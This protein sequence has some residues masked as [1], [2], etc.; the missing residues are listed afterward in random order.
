MTLAITMVI[1]IFKCRSARQ[2]RMWVSSMQSIPLSSYSILLCIKIWSITV[3][4][5]YA[6]L[7]NS[8]YT[9]HFY[10][11][12][13]CS[14]RDC[15][16]VKQTTASSALK[17]V[18]II[19]ASKLHAIMMI[20]IY[21][22]LPVGNFWNATGNKSQNQIYICMECVV[23]MKSFHMRDVFFQLY[24][25]DSYGFIVSLMSILCVCVEVND[26]AQ[27]S[28][29]L[30]INKEKL[31][32]FASWNA[33]EWDEWWLGYCLFAINI[34]Q[35][36]HTVV[37]FVYPERHTRKIRLLISF[38][39]FDILSLVNYSQLCYNYYY[40][41]LN[42]NKLKIVSV[43]FELIRIELNKWIFNKTKSKLWLTFFRNQW[44]Q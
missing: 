35:S 2:Y 1:I 7:L 9:I 32:K 23:C 31:I 28:W 29:Q 33:L 17:I 30:N 41:Y 39:H 26:T 21:G 18:S 16:A 27:K 44:F 37:I 12:Q 10:L 8:S 36:T 22:S 40:I 34:M 25:P 24:F 13:N 38:L 6:F 4:M 11:Y 42:R 15:A 5:W 43:T 20:C 19:L 3:H 14:H